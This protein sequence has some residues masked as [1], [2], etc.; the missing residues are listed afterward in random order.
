MVEKQYGNA[1][2]AS[3]QDN[4]A[5]VE[6]Q[7]QIQM[8]VRGATAYEYRKQL[9]EKLKIDGEKPEDIPAV[10]DKQLEAMGYNPNIGKEKS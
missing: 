3:L 4:I 8:N 10:I 5:K 2:L 9:A 1:I 6:P 7:A